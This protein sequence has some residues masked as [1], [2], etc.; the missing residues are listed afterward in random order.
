MLETVLETVRDGR[1]LRVARL[2]SGPPLILLHGYPDNLQIWSELARRLADKFEVIAFDWPGLGQSQTWP[3]G[4]TPFHMAERLLELLDAWGIRQAALVAM[5]MGAQP[6]L[7]FAAR[8]PERTRFL[9]AMNCLAYWDV[10]TSWE[11]AVLRRFGWNQLILKRFPTATVRRAENTFLPKGEELSKELRADLWESFKRKDVR[12]FII[13]MCAGYQGTLP[14]LPELYRQIA[15]PTLVLWGEQDKHFPPVH[16]ERLHSDI[17]GSE[18]RIIAGAE[19]WMALYL[20]ERVAEEIRD[21]DARRGSHEGN[22]HE[23]H[24]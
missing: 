9:V 17:Q 13:R 3:G 19:H 5:D 23:L 20:A 16:A 2:G 18:L 4:A 21:C 15:A 24:E 10:K 7:V 14:R 12:D 11:I 1:R 22:S 6:A 8:H